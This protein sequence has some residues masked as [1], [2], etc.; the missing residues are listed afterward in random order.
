[1]GV[2]PAFLELMS[3]SLGLSPGERRVC[4]RLGDEGS[5]CLGGPDWLL[6]VIHG[7][8]FFFPSFR[9]TARHTYWHSGLPAAW[10]EV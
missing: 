3:H 10:A 7:D 9:D 5:T 6:P 8:S 2:A 1:M 4:L